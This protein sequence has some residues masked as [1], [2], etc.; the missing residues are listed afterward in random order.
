LIITAG[1]SYKLVGFIGGF[2]I[3]PAGTK[4]NMPGAQE[5]VLADRNNLCEYL[6]TYLSLRE[7]GKPNRECHDAAMKAAKIQKV[8]ALS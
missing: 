4:V 1:Q 3:V 8:I 6:A 7:T 5:M 2:A